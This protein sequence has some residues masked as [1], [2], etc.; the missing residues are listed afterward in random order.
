MTD[1]GLTWGVLPPGTFERVLV[2]S[3]HFDDA[4]MGAGHLLLAHPGAIVCTVFAGRPERYPDEV[5]EWDA[6]GGFQTGDDVVAARREE[7]L[8]A[9]AVLGA[10]HHWLEFSDHQPRSDLPRP[11]PSNISTTCFFVGF[12]CPERTG[13]KQITSVWK[14]RVFARISAY[15]WT[16]AAPLL[17]ACRTRTKRSARKAVVPESTD[18]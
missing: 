4:A 16:K 12:G 1:H 3:P 11:P 2:F 15:G 5:T 13:S 18:A 7:D 17:R 8:A 10:Q 14:D 6:L 9:L